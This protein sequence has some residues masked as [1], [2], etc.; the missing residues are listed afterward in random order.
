MISGDAV[1]FRLG[2][3]P[4]ERVVFTFKTGR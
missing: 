1:V 2:G 3:R 4:G